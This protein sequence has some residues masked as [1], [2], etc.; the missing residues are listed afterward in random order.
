MMP[1]R[2][3]T[4]KIS[5]KRNTSQQ[6]QDKILQIIPQGLKDETEKTVRTKKAQSLVIYRGRVVHNHM[7]YLDDKISWKGPAD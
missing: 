5:E 3:D 2:V 7:Q 1:R 6:K 4:R